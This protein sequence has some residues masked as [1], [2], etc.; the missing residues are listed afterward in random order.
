MCPDLRGRK[1]RLSVA[2]NSAADTTVG[3][4]TATAYETGDPVTY[5]ITEGNGNGLFTIDATTG[6]I[7]LTR[8]PTDADGT[9][10]TITAKAQDSHRQ[11]NNV[12][13]AVALT[14]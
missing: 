8:A 6:V 7:T 12:Q 2:T 1:L 5:K 14:T 3:T 9:S 13:V 11:E 4:T 10:F